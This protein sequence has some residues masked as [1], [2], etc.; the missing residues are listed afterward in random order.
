MQRRRPD[1]ARGPLQHQRYG[2]ASVATCGHGG[3]P[4]DSRRSS[5]GG[6]PARSRSTCRR[7]AGS[8]SSSRSSSA[9]SVPT[10][11]PDAGP[12]GAGVTSSPPS[13]GDVTL[14]TYEAAAQRYAEQAARP[15]PAVAAYLDAVADLVGAG[16]VLELGSGPGRDADHLQ[17][18]GTHVVRT[19]GTRAF[20]AALQ[21][22]GHPAR[23]LDVR[24]DDLGGPYAAV[25]ANAVL[26]HLTRPELREVLV[27]AH[28]A[29]GLLAVTL[30]EGDG[31]GWTEAKLGLPRHFTYWREEPLREVL[32]ETGWQVASL[33]HV[34][35]RLEPWLLVLARAAP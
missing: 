2:W 30:K 28:R 19:D 16:T 9:G 25:M 4:V 8:V 18:R 10:G 6:A 24:T 31:E 11:A 23:L 20:V 26:L 1:A 15:G 32:R 3:P 5:G 33:D 29:A 35:G 21:A 7:R 34:A 14:A 17:A 22:A 27:R 13:P 12:Y